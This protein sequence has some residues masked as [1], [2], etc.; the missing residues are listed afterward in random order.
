MNRGDVCHPYMCM[1]LLCM[2]WCI[3]IDSRWMCGSPLTARVH[4]DGCICICVGPYVYPSYSPH[5]HCLAA[6]LCAPFFLPTYICSVYWVLYSVSY[7]TPEKCLY[8]YFWASIFS[9]LGWC[10]CWMVDPQYSPF[11][12]SFV[13]VS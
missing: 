4:I 10:G 8:K 5:H 2:V 1:P 13:C 11:H 6:P 3:E 9:C 12:A 7:W